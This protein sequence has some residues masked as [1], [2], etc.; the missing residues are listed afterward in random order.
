M[1]EQLTEHDKELILEYIERYAPLENEELI[2][3]Q[4]AGFEIILKEWDRQKQTLY[5]LLGN[6]FIVKRPYTYVYNTEAILKKMSREKYTPAYENFFRWISREVLAPLSNQDYGIYEMIQEAI[7]LSVLA[8]NKYPHATVTYY[9]PP[10]NEKFKVSKGMRPMR[11][12]SKIAQKYG[13]NEKTFEDF[14]LWHS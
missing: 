3:S 5:K 13:C 2:M 10:D 1:I 7:N 12:L 11:I 8:E 14:R 6:N 4:F 9:L